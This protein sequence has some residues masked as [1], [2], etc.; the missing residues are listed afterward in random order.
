MAALLVGPSL[1]SHLLPLLLLLI[2]L[3]TF[4]LEKHAGSGEKAG[5]CSPARNCALCK[6]NSL[7]LCIG[8]ERASAQGLQEA[9]EEDKGVLLLQCIDGACHIRGNGSQEG[10]RGYPWK[11]TLSLGMCGPL[12]FA[13]GKHKAVRHCSPVKCFYQTCERCL[14]KKCNYASLYSSR[15][16]T[17]TSG[18]QQ[19]VQRT[20]TSTCVPSLWGVKIR[21]KRRGEFK[22]QPAFKENRG[23]CSLC[24]G[25]SQVKLHQMSV[26]GLWISLF[27]SSPSEGFQR[28]ARDPVLRRYK[29]SLVCWTDGFGTPSNTKKCGELFR[30]LVCGDPGESCPQPNR[31]RRRSKHT[32]NCSHVSTNLDYKIVFLLPCADYFAAEALGTREKTEKEEEKECQMSLE[33]HFDRA[34]TIYNINRSFH[35]IEIHNQWELCMADALYKCVSQRHLSVD[36][37]GLNSARTRNLIWDCLILTVNNSCRKKETGTWDLL[38]GVK[39]RAMQFRKRLIPKEAG[40]RYG[41]QK[42]AISYPTLQEKLHPFPKHAPEKASSFVSIQFNCSDSCCD[43]LPSDECLTLISCAGECLQR[44]LRKETFCHFITV[45]F[46]QLWELLDPNQY[47]NFSLDACF[48]TFVNISFEGQVGEKCP[49]PASSQERDTRTEFEM[50]SPTSEPQQTTSCKGHCFFVHQCN[51]TKGSLK[52]IFFAMEPADPSVLDLCAHLQEK[53]S[54]AMQFDDQLHFRNPFYPV[55]AKRRGRRSRKRERAALP[56]IRTPRAANRH[57]HFPQ[58]NY[59]VLVAENQPPGTPVITLTAQDPDPGEAGRLLYAMDALMNSRS[60]ELFSI[61][62]VTG[63]ISTVEI[64]DREIMDLHYFRITAMDHGTPRL[65]ATTMISITVADRNDH[66]PVF[67]QTE[68][69]ETIRENVEEGYPIL[70]L[71]ATDGDSPANAN[72]RYRFLSQQAARSVFEIDPRSGLITTSGQVDREKMEKYSLIVEANDQGKEPGPRSATVKVYITVLDENDNV[73]Q[74]SEKRYIVQVRE[75]IRPHTEILRV[76]ATDLDKD[77]NALVHYNIISGNSRGQFAI[78]SVTGEMQV[79]ASL[80]FEVEREYS[81]RIRAQDAGRPPL[82]NNTGMVSIQVIDINDHSPIFV[83]TPFQVSVLENAAL[84][85][86][87]IHI[88]AVDADYGEN[89]R[90]EYKLTGVS[91]DTPFVINSATGWITVSGSL[92]REA[93]EHYFFGVEARDHGTPSLSASASVT[94]TVMDVNDNRPEFTQKEYF[95]R[96][97]EDASVGTNVLSVTAIDRD[98]NS[99]ISYQITGGNTRSRFAISTQGGVGLITLSLPLDYKQERRYVLTVTATDRTLHDTCHVYINVT[100]ANTHRPVFQSAHYSISIDEDRPI[101]NTVVVINA[102]DED[103]GENARITYFLDDNIPQFRINADTGAITLHAGLDH[104]DQVTYTLSITAKDNGIPQKSDTTYVEIIVKDVNDNA[105]QFVN[106]HYQ[107]SVSEDALPFTS[108]LQISATDRDAHANGRVQYTF[109]NGE[110]GDGDFTIEPTSGIIRTVRRLDRESVPVYE[111]T[112]YAVDRGTP[113]QRSPVR[114]QVT[115]QDVNDNAPVF[116]AEEFEVFVK[117]NSI[118][119]SVVARITAT[120]PDEGSNAQIMYQIVEGNIPEIFQM[121]IFSGELTALIDLDYETTAEYVIVVQA[122]SAPLVSRATVHIKLIDQNDNSPVLKNFQI[123]FNNYISNRS[124]TFPSGVI[125]KIPAY[126]PDVSDRLFYT[127]ERGNELNLLIVDQSSGEL[128]LSRKLDNNRPLMASMLVTV[129]DGI[130]SVTAQCVLRVIIITEDML[131]NSITVRLENM[132]QEHFLSPLL[133]SFLDG[134]ATVLAISK[135]DVFIFNIQNDMDVGGTILNVSFSALMPSGGRNQF[136]SSEDLQ[137]QLY[138]KRMTLTTVSMLEVMPF[139]DNVCLREPCENYMKCISVLKFDSSAPFIASESILFRPIHP[140]TGL[141]CR[142]PQGFT[143]DYCETEINLCYSNP[144]LN[145]GMCARREGGYTCICRER[146]TGD[147]CEVDSGAGR[148]V[149]GV[150]RN[151]GTCTN[152]ANGG[153]QCQCPSGGFEKPYCELSIRSF[154]PKSFV[155]FRGLR[156]RFRMSLSLS[157]ATLEKNGLLLY[158]GR[159]NEKHDFIA[160]EIIDGQVQ[161]KYS[162]GESTTVVTPYLPGGVSDGEWHTVQLQYYNKPKIGSMGVAQGP[163]KEKVAILALDDCDMSVALQYSSQIGN[164]TCAAEGVQ[165]SSKKSLDLTGPLLLGGVPN[166]PE[167]FPVAHKEFVGCMRNLYVDSKRIDLAAYI[168]NNGTSAGCHAKHSFCDSSPCKNG[169]SCSVTWGSFT[170]ECPLGFGGKD[171]RHAMHHPHRLQGNSILS[172]DFKNE[173]KISLPWFL[174]LAFRTR[175]PEGVLL[176]VHAGQYTTILCQL[177]SGLVS[178]SVNR[179]TSRTTK[180]LLD[181]M[182]VNDGKWHDLQ[183]ELRDVHSGRETRYVITISL[184]FGTYQDTVVVGNELHGLKVKHLHVGGILGSGKVQNG[185]EGCVQGIR[186]GE[187]PTGITL[188]KPSSSLNAE[189]GCSLA[190][191]CDSSSCPP[192][193]SCRDQWQSYSCACQPGHYGEKCTDVCQLNPCKNKSVCRR[194]PESL[195]GYV[196]DCGENYFGQ[197]CEHRMDQQCPKGWWG[198]QTCGPCNCD[199]NKGFDPD[200]NKT[201]GQCHCKDFHYCPKESDICLPC[202][203]YPIGSS[204]RSCEQET[205]QCTCRPGVIGRQCNACDNPFAEVT[206]N[207]CEVIYD[208]CPKALRAAVWWPRIKF[209]LPAA[210]PCPKGSLGVAFRHCDEEKGWLEPDLFN[211]TS[212]PFTELSTLLE[213]LEKNETELN[214][215]EAKK[216]AYRLSA[217]TEQMERYFGNDVQITYHLLSRLMEFESKQRGFGLTA[218]QDALFTENLLRAGS[219]VLALENKEHWEMLLQNENGSAGLMEQLREYT[220]TLAKNMKLTYL[221]P[222]GLVTP[223]IILSIDWMENHT[224]SRRHFPRYH[225]SL[226]RGQDT[227]DPHTHVVLPVSVLQPPKV[228][229]QATATPT[230]TSMELNTTAKIAKPKKVIP[231]PEPA[232]TILILII[233]RTLGGL[234]PA[235]YSTDRRS[236]RL[237]KNPVMNSPIVSVSVFRNHTFIQGVLNSPLTLE[238][239]LLETANR[240]KPLCVQ[241]NHSSQADAPG[242]WTARDCDLVYRNSTHVRCH[243]SQLGTFGV[244]MDSS[245]RE[246]LE[247]DLETLAIVTYSCLSVSLMAL[248]IAVFILVCLKGLKSNTRG[249]H[250]N[251]AVALFLSELVFLLGINHTE[252]QFLCT[253]IAILLHYFFL[254]TFAWLFVE[255]LH[256]YRMQT[257]VRNVNV[258]AMRFYYAIGWGVP[259]IITG[260]AVGLDPEGYGNPDFCWISVHDKLVWSFAGPIAVVILMN[261]VMFLM[262]ARMLCSPGQKEAKK[263]SVLITLRSSFVLLLVISTS[264]LFG[265]LAVNNSVVVFHYLYT[266]LCSLQGLAVLLLFC[267]LNEE[268]QGAW[269]LLCLG[270][271]SQSE[272]TAR[273]AQMAGPN[274]YNNTSL[275]EESGLI[276]ITLGAST[277]SSVSSVRS[278]RTHSSKRGFLRDN[279]AARQ[280]S[281]LDHSLLGHAGPTD[282]DVA[283]FHRD[284]GGGQDSDS[285]SDLSLDEER[286]LSIPSSESEENVRLR[287]RFQ[288]QFKRAAHSERLL[289]NPLN[290]SPK[291]VDGNDLMSYWPALGE[292]EV[293][294]CSLQ[295]WGS[296]R[297]LGLDL[298]KDAANNNQ[299]E[300]SLTSGDENSLT[301][302]HRQR[303]GILKNRLQ[304]PQALQGLSSVGR[305]TNELSWYKTSTL[306]HRAVPAASYGRMYSGAGSLSQ[307]A[308]RYSSREQLDMLMR[309]QMSKEQ[310]SRNNSRELLE[311]VPSR[312]ASNEQL[313]AIPNR[314]GSRDHLDTIPSRHGS[315]E[316]LES[317]PSRHGSRDNLDMSSSRNDQ[318]DHLNS[319]SRKQGSKEHLNTIPSRVGSRERIDCGPVREVSRE[320][321]NTLPTR[322]VSR[323]RMDTLPN[324]QTSREHLDLLSKRQPSRD[325]LASARQTSSEQLDILSRRSNSREHLSIVPSTHP[326]RENLELL[327]QRQP[328]RENLESLSGRLPSR[329]NEPLSR[330]QPSRENLEA[331]SS[332]YPSTEQLDILSSILASF[333]SSVLS[334]VQSSSTFSAPHNTTTPSAVQNSS[335]P[336]VLCPSTPHSATSHSIPDLSPDSEIVRSE[337][338][339]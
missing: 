88:Q 294:P 114:I 93:V 154:P 280:G 204:S 335:T 184:D 318:R 247:G 139:D 41:G 315:R 158:N 196:C 237:P 295:K 291:D 112:A 217:V 145:E 328:S 253:V 229:A 300:L 304:Y 262:L 191:A 7:A 75:D 110:D 206:P 321:L 181:Q 316:H 34:F 48:R 149:P 187:T 266:I 163:S 165:S 278:A 5:G 200:C 331:I 336:S 258:G 302:S 102:V 73:P 249:I 232:A 126:D 261:G 216:L 277:I 283:M 137:E 60:L 285:D 176:Q 33:R 37:G 25:I 98:V 252:N 311:V 210:V 199:V 127:F 105:P 15:K 155:M 223:N 182:L 9:E 330:R 94:I 16:R 18:I 290:T 47:C 271:K 170:C 322:Q 107:G 327:S 320:W 146:F 246:Q 129:T 189:A 195:R 288:R 242:R 152:L 326:S 162:T 12:P 142:C 260:L 239:R 310:L 226:F 268:V 338:H 90:M 194:K 168:A 274:S 273:P 86:S 57:P 303:K 186:L 220:S 78:D 115:V 124:N 38:Q 281:T 8:E 286:S 305:M 113:P 21:Y 202:D 317:I 106:A 133:T 22:S 190:N 166:L 36:K 150:C 52:T 160:V 100:D 243:C 101:G 131:A 339:S 59:Q 332:R 324:R 66:D 103:V 267:V 198:N 119:G 50:R 329:D 219:S 293:H 70:Q 153:F 287:G 284:A 279:M 255:G 31:S 263:K 63:L 173:L 297:K 164:Y 122:T 275:F 301:Q 276:R 23:V 120:D 306:G 257:E 337:G 259:A 92:D 74:F 69:R 65:S 148:C 265:L 180:L 68:Y 58:H 248:L 174:G 312:H 179:G 56:L 272:E 228:E 121:D 19:T 96:L 35:N 83:S 333:N 323:D 188:P 215:I 135:E 307:P 251:I 44:L 32:S 334:N 169:G 55:N 227:W 130:H 144:C 224:H 213:S 29:S 161:L 108:V 296:E 14:F 80:D 27:D 39:Q 51:S 64:L 292:C 244:L 81:L 254:S 192:N 238:F 289:T 178:F 45:G 136:F 209:G 109:Q 116:P 42:E 104:E 147:N 62:S 140:I 193:S 40:H 53:P 236:V 118:V 1:S 99:A 299:P 319:L 298:T 95:I 250:I 314:H 171:C 123:L 221:N 143:G 218:T 235:R 313:D 3:F 201:T 183:L 54:K 28:K 240:S 264:W 132:S 128:K 270:K 225:S 82:S 172:W 197:Y 269:K 89:S 17:K 77:N 4:S 138:M 79:V 84:G 241:W 233:Y 212:P 157:F 185:L 111:L 13:K 245:H 167:N 10:L 20:P 203:C 230:L 72:I 151:G 71:R 49:V 26:T 208:G 97:N 159:L 30:H 282:L 214:T 61:D 205:G 325:Q 43:H 309:R 91:P 211:C 141:R 156:Q 231:E 256:I 177:V 6:K 175:R 2:S 125:G 222:V 134:V 117:E 234:L 207:G 87:V 46:N 24:S 76:T 11:L 85:H 308:S 67:E